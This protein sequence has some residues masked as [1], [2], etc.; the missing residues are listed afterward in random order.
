[1]NSVVKKKEIIDFFKSDI[2]SMESA[3]MSNNDIAYDLEVVYYD[4]KIIAVSKIKR[5]NLHSKKVKKV[6]YVSN[7]FSVITDKNVDTHFSLIE[8]RDLMF[9]NLE[10]VTNSSFTTPVEVIKIFVTKFKHVTIGDSR[11]KTNE[12]SQDYLLIITELVNYFDRLK[13]P[14]K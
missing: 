13:M 9:S 4:S 5:E 14:Y 6:I 12:L 8:K 2:R 7:D 11:H 1:M 10:A 3:W